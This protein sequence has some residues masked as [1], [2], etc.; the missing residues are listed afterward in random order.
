MPHIITKS[1][2]STRKVV[3]VGAGPAGLE[4]ARVSRERGHD[5]VLFESDG[6]VG[7]QIKLAA[8]APQRE[9]MAGIIRWFELEIKRLGI[10]CRFNTEASADAILRESPDIV[11]LA[12][13]GRPNCRE[14]PGWG[15]AEGL[16]ESS[17]DILSGRVEPGKRVLVYD[18]VSTHA[19][20]GVAD[21]IASRGGTVE[22]V[23]PDVKVAD[24]VGGTT[25]PIFYR[26]LYELDVV[27]TP[28]WWLDR[29]YDEGDHKVAVLRNEYTERLEERVVDQ[30]VVENGSTPNDEL[31]WELKE[32]SI[33]H[34]ETDINTLF[35]N[36][37][38]P[39][40]SETLGGSR[41]ALFRVGDCISPHNIHGAIYD[42]LRL[43]KDF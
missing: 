9:Q 10:D 24:D 27:L 14:V 21:F 35:D 7:G 19:G 42:A 39:V 1:T 40:L 2:G 31:Y 13:G 5:V 16:A 23:T 37:P 22:I 33:N 6:A 26:R 18:G 28:N 41:F 11:V 3:V 25:F 34:G 29:V 38:Q 30:V 32:R 43:C 15:V 4:A 20:A 17:W 36:Q 8:K 12:T